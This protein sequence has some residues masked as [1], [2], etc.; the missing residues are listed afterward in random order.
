MWLACWLTYVTVAKGLAVGLTNPAILQESVL[1]VSG[2]VVVGNVYNLILIYQETKLVKELFAYASLGG[3]LALTLICG[4][5]F[6]W[7]DPERILTPTR[8]SFLNLAFL[9]DAGVSGKLLCVG[10]TGKLVTREKV[11]GD[12]QKSSLVVMT[13]SLFLT[14]LVAIPTITV[15][16]GGRRGWDIALILFLLANTALGFQNIRRLFTPLAVQQSVIF[17]LLVGINLAA[18]FLSVFTGLDTV[19]V[20]WLGDRFDLLA[21][22]MVVSLLGFSL[23]GILIAGM[24]R[25]DNDYRYGHVH[26]RARRWII[27]GA[28]LF[29]LI[30]LFLNC[31]LM[32]F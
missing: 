21:C 1:V 11:T 2:L 19:I 4:L 29:L 8:L 22:C 25:Y 3:V 10:N 5:V 20:R 27:A 15:G 30:L 18:L 31:L 13:A 9:G 24:Q 14:A 17:Q 32:G 6:A 16:I 26:G 7:S 12:D 28:V 23:S